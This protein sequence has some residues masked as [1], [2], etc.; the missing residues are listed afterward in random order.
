MVQA[1][2]FNGDQVTI[3][4]PFPGTSTYIEILGNGDA[5]TIIKNNVCSSGNGAV[6][7]GNYA[8]IAF[9][10]V[11]LTTTCSTGFD[12]LGQDFA[13]ISL[14][15]PL[16]LGPAGSSGGGLVDLYD[17]SSLIG[18]ASSAVLDISG[19]G[20][21][22]F[23]VSTE[24]SAN[25]SVGATNTITNTPNFTTFVDVIDNS[26]F[27][28]GTGGSFSGSIGTGISYQLVNNGTIDMENETSPLPGTRGIVAGVSNFYGPQ[29]PAIPCVGGAGGCPDVTAPTGLGGT[30]FAS[31]ATGSGDHSG[32]VLLNPSGSGIAAT[33]TVHISTFSE[34]SGDYGGEGFCAASIS[35]GA[36]GW[37]STSLPVHTTYS[38]GSLI[39]VWNTGGGALTT[40]DTYAITYTCN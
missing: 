23:L 28:P 27:N 31:L 1:A 4:G 18:G 11:Q 10:N 40:S 7:V 35:D 5:S 37:L 13:H 19:G 17:H 20:S 38:A 14:A 29:I 30:G 12:L 15:G 39:L 2:T 36:T 16:G 33:G 24:S 25:L 22:G 21:Y 3:E 34:L 8:N 26:N 6:Y 32:S 9:N